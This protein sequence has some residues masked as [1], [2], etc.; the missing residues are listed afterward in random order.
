V[1]KVCPTRAYSG[2][3]EVPAVKCESG[4]I[5]ITAVQVEPTKSTAGSF[6]G[7]QSLPPSSSALPLAPPEKIL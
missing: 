1:P 7:S 5:L 3:F 6:H 2:A 4:G